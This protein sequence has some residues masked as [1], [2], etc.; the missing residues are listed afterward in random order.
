M[1]TP[2]ECRPGS[3]GRPAKPDGPHRPRERDG[4]GQLLLDDGDRAPRAV[5]VVSVIVPDGT[6]GRVETTP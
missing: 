2:I 1:L 4:P 3:R 5:V 6:R